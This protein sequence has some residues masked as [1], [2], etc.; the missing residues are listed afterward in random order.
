MSSLFGN[1]GNLS[2]VLNKMKEMYASM[3][4]VQEE[5]AKETIEATSGG[6]MVKVVVSGK[7]DLLEIKIDPQVVD[8]NDVEMLEDLVTTAVREALTK[9]RDLEAERMREC[10]G[11]D[12]PANFSL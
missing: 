10:T 9:A 3:Q 6:G 4:Q 2:G 1:L 5:L 11:L 12:L 7:R 8:P